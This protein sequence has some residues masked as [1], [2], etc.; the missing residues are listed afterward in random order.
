[1]RYLLPLLALVL[2]PL[3]LTACTDS[4]ASRIGDRTYR[5]DSPSVPGG[6]EGP[7]RRL[8]N[9]LCPSGY[10]V[11]TSESHKGGVD[12]AIADDFGTTTIWTIKCL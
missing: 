7:N 6:A 12:R 5:I 11:L 8:A 10:R 9:Q 4:E 3:T 2:L 1:M